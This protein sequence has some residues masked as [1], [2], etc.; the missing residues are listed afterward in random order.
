MMEKILVTGGNGFIGSNFIHLMYENYT[1]MEI[2]NLDCLDFEITAENHSHL[3]SSRYHELRANLLDKDYLVKLF[4][5]HK[6]TGIVNFAANSHVDNS[7]KSPEL[8]PLNNIIG[9]QNLLDVALKNEIP[10]FLHISTDEVY[11]SLELDTPSTTEESN[12]LPNNPYSASKAGADCLVR[13]YVKTFQMPCKITRSSNN[14]GPYQYPEKFIPVVISKILADEKI[15]VYGQ[16]LNVRDWILARDNC[17]AVDLVRTKGEF[18]EIYNIPG[19]KEITNIELVKTILKVMGKDE[20]LISFVEDRKGHD[21][22]Y[23]MDGSKI[24]ALGFSY[25]TSFE[26]ALNQTIEWYKA[27]PK[28]LMQSVKA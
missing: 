9:T 21:L 6:F 7:I 20:S 27:N 10:S 11:G 16:G 24:E 2:F 3:D 22:R 25:E 8:F 4:K 1:D 5:E 14:F 18:G 26:D 19:Y 13:S 28:F 17:R 12:L 15:P 23:S